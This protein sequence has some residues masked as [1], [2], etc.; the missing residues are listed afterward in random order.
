MRIVKLLISTVLLV[1]G[2]VANA[3]FTYTDETEYLTVL[4]TMGF[5]VI[6]EGFED[7][8]VWADSRTSIISPGSTPSV[9]S[10]GI[11]WTSNFATNN[12]ATSNTGVAGTFGL[13]SSPHGDP[14]VETDETL[15]NADPIPEQCFLHDGFVGNSVGAGTLYG[16]GAWINGTFGAEVTLFL[17][18]VEVGFGA[19]G[20]ISGWTFLGVIDA[21][22][23]NSVE[24]REINGKAIE[25]LTIRTDDVTFGVSAVPVPAAVWLL[26]SGLLGLVGMARRKKAA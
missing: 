1:V 5:A 14:N 11:E 21:A 17:D 22:G 15:C 2:S 20:G 13:F 9:I 4:A 8:T 25:V 10:Q 18:G 16:V 19:D 6:N 24:F 23:F 12:I 3:A 26:G 7:D